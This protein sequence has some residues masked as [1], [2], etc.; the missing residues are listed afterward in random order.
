MTEPFAVFILTHGRPDRVTTLN[1]LR[2]DNC[3]GP[4][5]LVIDDEDD[6]ADEYRKQHDNVV[7]FN[8][9]AT[10]DRIDEGHNNADRRTIV[11][12]RDEVY[13]IAADLG[14]RWFVALD[15]DYVYFAYRWTNDYQWRTYARIRN[16]DDVFTTLFG[17]YQTISDK[18]KTIAFSQTGDFLG[19]ENSTHAKGVT[20]KRKAMNL[21]LCDTANPVLFTG[22]LNED[23]NAYTEGQ[24]RGDAVFTL[25]GLYLSQ[26]PTQQQPG[27]LTN[28]YRAEGT[29]TKSM[30]SVI[31][32]PSAVRLSLM[33][34]RFKRIHH[35]V[36][37]N[38]CAPQILRET[39]RKPR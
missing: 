7:M 29:Y 8:K 14:Y 28:I 37:Y 16:L 35:K 11:Y 30:Y 23:V 9:K 5:Y 32:C 21:F 10:A 24:R 4:V 6:T 27:G 36:N 13:R 22:L 2:R 17:W 33:G 26:Q 20:A 15:D 38:N 1:T 19:G 3:T 25:T 34:E 18:V 39:L 31:R 12:A